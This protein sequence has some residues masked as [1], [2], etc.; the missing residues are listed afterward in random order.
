MMRH[1]KILYRP[2]FSTK[3]SSSYGKGIASNLVTEE[4]R[5]KYN[6]GGRV[7]LWN[8]S[9]YSRLP[10]EWR[11]YDVNP[12]W[13]PRRP[14]KTGADAKREAE[15]KYMSTPFTRDVGKGILGA[16]DFIG[17]WF[18]QPIR[19]GGKHALN[20]LAGTNLDTSG[21]WIGDEDTYKKLYDK[22]VM[23]EATKLS[24]KHIPQVT[25]E[26]EYDQEYLDKLRRNEIVDT[27]TLEEIKT[28]KGTEEWLAEDQETEVGNYPGT[29]L[30]KDLVLDPGA[31]LTGEP[32][33][34]KIEKMMAENLAQSK[35]SA[36]LAAITRGVSMASNLLT[37]PTMAKAVGKAG[38]EAPLLAKDYAA[39]MKSAEAL[40]IQWEMIKEKAAI[41]GEEKIKLEQEKQKGDRWKKSYYEDVIDIRRK[42]LEST[43]KDVSILD[44][45]RATTLKSTSSSDAAAALSE[46]LSYRGIPLGTIAVVDIDELQKKPKKRKNHLGKL[47]K[48]SKRGGLWY[49]IKGDGTIGEGLTNKD[50][51]E[52][53]FSALIE[54][55][56]E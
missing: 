36:K 11:S 44:E 18:E 9:D 5:V 2:M 25:E 21:D 14:I 16:G 24:Q 7:G 19:K 1:P 32:T 13:N 50:V 20:Y 15:M 4:Q 42:E 51:S 6:S 55:K 48:D 17:N 38:K 35:K 8:G 54:Q 39:A 27:E 37:E 30:A 3:G 10:D 40:P 52:I 56:S 46:A 12:P 22:Y 45:L 31:D 49:I 33:Q 28:P 53:D 26:D 43:G 29:E 47:V 23:P 34:S 41:E